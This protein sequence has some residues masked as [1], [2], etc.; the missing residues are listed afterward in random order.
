MEPEV[1]HGEAPLDW[2]HLQNERSGSS[3]SGAAAN[4]PAINKMNAKA[5][6]RSSG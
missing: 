3:Y 1:G 6:E 4:I 5:N 2:H